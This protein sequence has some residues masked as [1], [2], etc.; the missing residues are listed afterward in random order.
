M[1]PKKEGKVQQVFHWDASQRPL[2]RLFDLYE[3]VRDVLCVHVHGYSMSVHKQ[4]QQQNYNVSE[5]IYYNYSIKFMHQIWL[6]NIGGIMCVYHISC[7]YTHTH[8]RT[9]PP[10]HI[11]GCKAEIYVIQLRSPFKLKKPTGMCAISYRQNRKSI[12][13]NLW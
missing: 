3:F 5:H 6:H 7:Q 9:P 13:R 4:V 2:Q 10:P 8:A 11:Q 1:L 12:I